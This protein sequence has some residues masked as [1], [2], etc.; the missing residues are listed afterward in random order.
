M[1]H[2]L[3]IQYDKDTNLTIFFH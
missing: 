3:K 2:Q 1:I